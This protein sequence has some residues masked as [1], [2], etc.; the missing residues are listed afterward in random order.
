MLADRRQSYYVNA[1]PHPSINVASNQYQNWL[2]ATLK[3][4]GLTLSGMVPSKDS[5]LRSGN[6]IIGESV[7]VKAS[8]RGTLAEFNDF[9]SKFY[10]LDML[11]RISEIKLKPE[12][13]P[14]SSPPVR[15][16]K[17]T[18]NMTFEFLSLR[19]AKSRDS[20]EEFR[21]NL[22]NS[23]K[24]YDEILRRNIFGPANSE[25]VITNSNKTH[26]EG[27]P[28]S[29]SI[30]AK[31]ANNKDQLKFELVKTSVDGAVLTQARP[32]DRRAKFQMPDVPPGEYKF[33]V[34]VSDDGFPPKSSINDFTVTVNEKRVDTKKSVVKEKPPEPEPEV[35]YIQLV[36]V[37]GIT[38]DRNGTRRVWV[39]VGKT[40]ERPRLAVGEAFKIDEKEYVVVSIDD[41][42]ATF[43][44][45]GR[46][47]V[48]SPDFDTR[49]ALVEIEL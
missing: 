33:E 2:K 20:F 13:E 29:T 28:F 8:A 31:D 16:G 44:G 17:I 11:H 5:R 18:A 3:E 47:F 34:K 42:K 22:V 40:G 38:S 25:P 26:T 37:T 30:T 49:G 24:D 9:L 7:R 41:D 39:S 48:A 19:A 23:E 12:N 45:D 1:S 6:D 14:R 43:E 21:K 32:S 4:S 35:D 27:R 10:Q 46:T 36:R 15:N